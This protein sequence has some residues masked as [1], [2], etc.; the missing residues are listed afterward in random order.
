MSSAAQD[1][2]RRQ[3]DLEE[4]ARAFVG[5][6]AGRSVVVESIRGG[7]IAVA[8]AGD[9]SRPAA[10]LLKVPLVSAALEELDLTDSVTRSELGSTSFAT[11]LAAFD[12]DPPFHAARALLAVPRDERQ[13]RRGV[14]AGTGRL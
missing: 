7:T 13:R 4:V 10:S 3:G 6:D 11:V 2:D 14:P 9:V 8:V 12:D 1:V 5:D